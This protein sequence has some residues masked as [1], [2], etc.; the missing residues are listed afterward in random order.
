MILFKLK[1]KWLLAIKLSITADEITKIFFIHFTEGTIIFQKISELMTLS[2]CPHTFWHQEMVPW[3][4]GMRNEGG[5][6]KE[7]ILSG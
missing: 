7:R 4:N 3:R 2:S 6:D 1:K 5:E